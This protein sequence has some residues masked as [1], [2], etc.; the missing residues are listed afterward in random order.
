MDE[1]KS[2]GHGREGSMEVWKLDVSDFDS[3][4]DFLGKWHSSAQPVHVLIN[5][6]G[7]FDMAGLHCHS[8]SRIFDLFK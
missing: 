6:A 8:S 5:N 2:S 4:R 3:I 7:I 1:I